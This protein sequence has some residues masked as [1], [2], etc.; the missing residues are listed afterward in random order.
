MVSNPLKKTCFLLV[1]L[2]ILVLPLA[3]QA[4]G[5]RLLRLRTAPH[6]GATRLTL[7]FQAPPDYTISRLPDRLRL[8]IR[9]ADSPAFKRYRGYADAV[10]SG[11]FCTQRGG[12]LQVVVKLKPG[13]RAQ[14]A[15]V[16][17][18]QTLTL[19]LSR[20]PAA[21]AKVEIVPGREG[22]L[23]G[24]EKLVA[25]FGAPFNSALPFAP[26]DPKRLQQMLPEPEALLFQRGEDVLYKEQAADAIRVF[27]YF[28]NRAPA[29]R[30]LA[31]YRLGE[32]YRQL[33]RDGEAVAAFRE[34]ER[35]QPDYLERAP[36]VAECYAEVRARSGDYAGGRGMLSRL[37]AQEAGGP[38]AA[39]LM[40]HLAAMQNR[41]GD[42]QGAIATYRAVI[43]RFPAS[44]AAARARM[45]LVDRELFTLSPESYKALEK[46]Y[47]AL[48]DAPADNALRDEA[49][50]KMALIEA[51]YGPAQEAL[52]Q[53][54][55]YEKRYP[56]GLLVTVAKRMREE[57]L[58]PVYKEIFATHDDKRLLQLALDHKEYLQ[59]A[60][61][62]PQFARRLGDACRTGNMLTVE[63]SLFGYLAEKSWAGPS[64]PYMLERLVVDGRTLGK[65]ETAQ[66]AGRAYLSRFPK[67]EAAQRIREHL[68]G[69]AFEKGDLKGAGTELGFLNGKK[70]PKPEF[71]ESNY[72]LGKALVAAGDRRGGERALSRFAAQASGGSPLLPDTYFSLASTRE[73]LKDAAGAIAAYREGLKFASG[74]TAEGFLYKM[75]ELYLKLNRVKEAG[76]AWE[77]VA[78][79]GKDGTWRKMATERLDDLN[80][81]LKMSKELPPRSKN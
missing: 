36:E 49:L 81:R 80:W 68:G 23:K 47:Q 73:A 9:G 77:K 27:T 55:T 4:Q 15:S 11:I 14:I 62:D 72:Y 28:L 53:V 60:L 69:I 45:K 3:G 34:G 37:I 6:A 56:R 19:D 33:Q 50:F 66:E 22:I 16:A 39:P 48:Y 70:A 59:V 24:T 67:G 64:A 61:T 8:T 71:A 32:A 41:H 54:V 1:L 13:A 57:L 2:L 10:V 26:T 25:E 30:A 43:A 74:E 76:A 52:A 18:P 38:Y 12:D 79:Q 78:K 75:G 65:L 42:E 21:A 29:V 31:S 58:L 51:L 5:N 20:G 63:L 35:L 7:L 40:N 17:D 46:R 44:S